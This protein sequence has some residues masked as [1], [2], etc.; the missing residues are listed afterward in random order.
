MRLLSKNPLV[1]S[2][3]EGSYDSTFT[4]SVYQKVT[5]QVTHQTTMKCVESKESYPCRVNVENMPPVS[6]AGV[7]PGIITQRITLLAPEDV[8]IPHGSLIKVMAAGGHT[9]MYEASGVPVIYLHHQEVELLLR[10][11]HP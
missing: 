5:D 11:E 1:K 9:T 4:V 3:I 8:E 10:E 2:F 6:N 7:S